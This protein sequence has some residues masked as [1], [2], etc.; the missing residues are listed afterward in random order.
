[1]F[2]I[3]AEALSLAAHASVPRGTPAHREL[4]P[5]ARP[6]PSWPRQG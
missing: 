4:P 6:A 1:M 3:L 2:Q 5:P